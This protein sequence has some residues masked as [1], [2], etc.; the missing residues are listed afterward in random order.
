MKRIRQKE[1]LKQRK[2]KPTRAKKCSK[3]RARLKKVRGRVVFLDKQG[4]DLKRTEEERKE[5][6][7]N[8]ENTI[9][10]HCT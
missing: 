2:N 7:K 1:W 6:A 8:L 3:A 10:K 9:K 4:N 5:I